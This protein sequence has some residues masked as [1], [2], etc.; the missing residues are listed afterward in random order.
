MPR[1]L[2]TPPLIVEPL[3]QADDTARATVVPA[4]R[5]ATAVSAV[6]AVLATAAL[7]VSAALWV[8][9]ARF[10]PLGLGLAGLIV[11]WA[12]AT[13]TARRAP[14]A[15]R[16]AL[17][18]LLVTSCVA[19]YPSVDLAMSLPRLYGVVLGVATLGVL[20]RWIGSGR[21][22][23]LAEVPLLLLSAGIAGAGLVATEWPIGGVKDTALA[24]LDLVYPHLPRLVASLPYSAARGVNPNK[25]AAP[26]AML[27]PLAAGAVLFGPGR[28]PLRLAWGTAGLLV[29][30]V[31]VLT[32]SRSAWLAAGGALLFLLVVRWRPFALLLVPFLGLVLWGV[33][34]SAAPAPLVRGW[35]A[36]PAAEYAR[37]TFASRWEVWQLGWAMA[38]DFPFTGIGLGT[39]PRV[40]EI[41]YGTALLYGP[42]GAPPHAH[43][44]LLQVAVDLGAPGLGFFLLLTACT[45]VAARRAIVGT[46]G[47]RV[48][49]LAIG[50]AGGLLAYYL[51]GLTDAIGLGEKPGILFWVLL[52][53]IASGARLASARPLPPAD[54]PLALERAGSCG[55]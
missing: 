33:V 28:W 51:Y 44:L 25:L 53:V 7:G 38:R 27:L 17:G 14:G 34:W 35:A 11:L 6:V 47:R 9:P 48:R 4:V 49:G 21:R 24:S 52:A 3:R 23:W 37:V 31:L 13:S 18:G 8:A 1:A 26:L 54:H 40:A 42:G 41:L 19:L 30:L 45:A 5:S 39:F 16:I 43:N 20:L 50:A 10:W 55:G 12:A 2:V 32:Q 46:A 36:P 15:W 22:L 29:A